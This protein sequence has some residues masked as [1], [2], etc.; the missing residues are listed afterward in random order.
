MS[1]TFLLAGTF[2]GF[3]SVAFGAFGAHA[4]KSRLD[5][6]SL[7]VFHTGVDYQF[8]HAFALLFVGVLLLTKEVNALTW[9]GYAFI[10]GIFVFSGSLYALALTGVKMW[11]AVTPIGGVG[12]LVG[13]IFLFKAILDLTHKG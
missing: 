2:M 11:G 10:F 5:E 4:L 3:F 9:A 12:F 8:Y 1:R 6:Y 13:W 7:K